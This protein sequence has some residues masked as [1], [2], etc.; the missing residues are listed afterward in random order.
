MDES[1]GC[2]SGD[3]VGMPNWPH[4]PSLDQYE[5]LR[6]VVAGFRRVVID[7]TQGDRWAEARIS[8]AVE[9]GWSGFLLEAEQALRGQSV[10]VS[11]ADAAGPGVPWVRFYM[12]PDTSG[13]ELCYEPPGAAEACRELARKLAEVLGYEFETHDG[14]ESAEPDVPPESALGDGSGRS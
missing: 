7:W 13:M 14:G 6:R 4:G 8:K 5:I 3:I 2:E 11:L 12:T 10:L 9:I 1:F